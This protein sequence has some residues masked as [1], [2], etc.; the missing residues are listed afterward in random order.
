MEA[1]SVDELRKRLDDNNLVLI[2]IRED[3]EHEEFN[4][5]GQCLPMGE[6]QN[7]SAKVLQSPDLEHVIY[8]RSGSRSAMVAAYLINSGAQNVK[9]LKGGIKAWTATV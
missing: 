1:I 8:C 7:W 3:Y 5:G 6:I 2:D 4:I 9:S